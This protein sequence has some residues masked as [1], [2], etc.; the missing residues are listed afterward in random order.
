M[1]EKTKKLCTPLPEPT[2]P[3]DIID[4]ET[5]KHLEASIE[6]II[7][8]Y[9]IYK[10]LRDAQELALIGIDTPV[11]TIYYKKLKEYG[12]ICTKEQYKK[13]LEEGIIV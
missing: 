8:E 7:K 3:E 12:A 11:Y 9:G 6:K 2:I 1:N 13:Q 4:E 5:K 10:A